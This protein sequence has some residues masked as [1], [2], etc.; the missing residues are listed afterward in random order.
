MTFSP[1][2]PQKKKRKK[3][4]LWVCYIV[5]IYLAVDTRGETSAR[6]C[7]RVHLSGW[8]IKWWRWWVRWWGGK[9][10]VHEYMAV[11]VRQTLN[12]PNPAHVINRN[13]SGHNYSL[14]ICVTKDSFQRHWNKFWRLYTLLLIPDVIVVTCLEIE[15]FYAEYRIR[16]YI[17]PCVFGR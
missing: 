2:P 3:W 4:W 12:R 6:I 13:F 17:L 11:Q 5:N 1:P 16:N 14:Q 9:N 8:R 10:G 15:I 7:Q